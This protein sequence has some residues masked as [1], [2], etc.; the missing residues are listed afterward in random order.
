MDASHIGRSAQEVAA[1]ATQAGL[2][3]EEA[4]SLAAALEKLR[5][6]SW[7]TPPRILFAGSL[8]FAGEVLAANDTPPR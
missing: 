3:A 5:A 6:K 8:Y 4:P 1:F 7:D 2:K